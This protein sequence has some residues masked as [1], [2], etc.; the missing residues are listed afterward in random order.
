MSAAVGTTVQSV[1]KSSVPVLSTI[2]EPRQTLMLTLQMLKATKGK[3]LTDALIDSGA[4]INC[5]KESLLPLL[6]HQKIQAKRKLLPITD[7][8]GGLLA[9]GMNES[10]MISIRS[11]L[12]ATFQSTEFCS[13]KMSKFNIILGMPWLLKNNLHIN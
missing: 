3:M 10:Y 2:L 11:S 1:T 4:S 13:V 9:S 5:V 12:N 6:K 7:V 8:N